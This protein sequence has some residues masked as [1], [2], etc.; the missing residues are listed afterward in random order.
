MLNVLIVWAYT[1]KEWVTVPVGSAYA[2]AEYH[3]CF[4]ISIFESNIL[5]PEGDNGFLL[6]CIV[7]SKKTKI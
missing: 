5:V 6:C 3:P 7:L 1:N 2:G 4:D